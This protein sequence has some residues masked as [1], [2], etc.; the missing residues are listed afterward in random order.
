VTLERLIARAWL[1]ELRGVE[2]I[3]RAIVTGASDPDWLYAVA[4]LDTRVA[5]LRELLRR[6][7]PELLAEAER[8][9]APVASDCRVAIGLQMP[10]LPAGARIH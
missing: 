8:E 9:A 4:A 7:D 1:Q 3:R 10:K 2:R 6:E 5:A